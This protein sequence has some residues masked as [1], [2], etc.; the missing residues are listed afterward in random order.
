MTEVNCWEPVTAGPSALTNAI[1]NSLDWLVV[2]AGDTTDREIED[3]CLLTTLSV[4]TP[5][6]ALAGSGTRLKHTIAA[7]TIKRSKIARRMNSS[8]VVIEVKYAMPANAE[9]PAMTQ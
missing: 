5:V 9:G 7:M 6:A 1:N 2:K 3:W 4:A 8:Q